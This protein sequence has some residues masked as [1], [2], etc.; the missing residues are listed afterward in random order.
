MSYN[1]IP[2]Q[3]LTDSDVHLIA[4]SV[5][6]HPTLRELTVK[7]CL[8]SFVK[9]AVEGMAR[10]GGVEKLVLTSWGE[11]LWCIPLTGRSN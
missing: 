4:L 1:L 9:G 6:H 10:R 2:L 3:S 8:R 5:E 11:C 7:E